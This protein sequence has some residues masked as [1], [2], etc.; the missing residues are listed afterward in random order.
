MHDIAKKGRI[1][2]GGLLS[3]FA[4]AFFRH[5]AVHLGD[6]LLLQID[7]VHSF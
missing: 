4:T 3:V 5:S 1:D 6:F 2:L 7:I